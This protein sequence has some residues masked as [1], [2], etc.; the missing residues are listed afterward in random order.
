M[1]GTNGVP[2]ETDAV[3]HA[4]ELHFAAHERARLRL[5][6]EESKESRKERPAKEEKIARNRDEPKEYGRYSYN[7]DDEDDF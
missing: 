2:L 7:E 3:R 5:L 6:E 4:K 1:I